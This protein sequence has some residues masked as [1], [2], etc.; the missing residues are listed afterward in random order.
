V[1]VLLS[2]VPAAVYSEF[3]MST[4]LFQA[5]GSGAYN[6]LAK[7][8]EIAAI[9]GVLDQLE[10]ER[11]EA[12]AGVVVDEGSREGGDAIVG[13][14]SP[15][16]SPYR[17]AAAASPTNAAVLIRGESETGKKLLARTIHDVSGRDSAFASLNCPT[18]VEKLVES[19]LFG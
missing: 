8:S 5:V 18:I 6:Y 4:T 10:K 16:I 15:M 19:E 1:T 2:L 12:V 11:Y 7:P 3:L 9:V 17:T 14:A 13:K